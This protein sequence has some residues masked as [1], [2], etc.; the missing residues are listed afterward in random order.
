MTDR[1]NPDP[2]SPDWM[3]ADEPFYAPL[4]K[5]SYPDCGC[6]GECLWC[7]SYRIKTLPESLD[8]WT[9]DTYFDADG[10]LRTGRDY[11]PEPLLDGLWHAP[12]V[13]TSGS[14]VHADILSPGPN[15]SRK[16]WPG[17]VRELIAWSLAGILLAGLAYALISRDLR[18]F[19]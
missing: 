6:H 15:R 4:P 16:R 5:Y 11:G 14:F 7:Q 19:Q 3:L 12:S 8:R 9:G 18:M 13:I 1:A 2:Y 10:N 17:W